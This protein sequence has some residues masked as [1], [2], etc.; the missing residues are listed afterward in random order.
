MKSFEEQKKEY[1]NKLEKYGEFLKQLSE[2]KENKELVSIL[3]LPKDEK[4]L[5]F[6]NHYIMF[7]EDTIGVVSNAMCENLVKINLND[8]IFIKYM[9]DTINSL[10]SNNSIEEIK[11]IKKKYDGTDPKTTAQVIY[12]MYVILSSDPE[13]MGK[14]ICDKCGFDMTNQVQLMQLNLLMVQAKESLEI[15][16]NS[17]IYDKE[18]MDVFILFADYFHDF[19]MKG[20][21][22]HSNPEVDEL[23]ADYFE[24]ETDNKI[25]TK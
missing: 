19:Y 22:D 23:L 5:E 17:N 11:K 14:F 12:E 9:I 25:F 21:I 15:G 8:N 3:L 18:G 20:V 1:F 4:E 7:L 13:E 24:E 6:A 2:K 10:Y 16:L